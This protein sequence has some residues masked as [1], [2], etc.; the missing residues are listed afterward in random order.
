MAEPLRRQHPVGEARQPR[1]QNP[2]EERPRAGRGRGRGGRQAPAPQGQPRHGIVVHRGRRIVTIRPNAFVNMAGR[3]VSRPR[4][5]AWIYYHTLVNPNPLYPAGSQG[6]PSVRAICE[7]Y[8][9]DYATG[10]PYIN[11]I[12]TLLRETGTHPDRLPDY[13]ETED[14][15]VLTWRDENGAAHLRMATRDDS[16]SRIIAEERRRAALPRQ[17]HRRHRNIPIFHHSDAS[18]DEEENEERRESRSRSRSPIRARSLTPV[19]SGSDADSEH[20]ED[21]SDVDMEVE[22]NADIAGPSPPNTPPMHAPASP[23]AQPDAGHTPP[24]AGA[25]INDLMSL[26]EIASQEQRNAIRAFLGDGGPPTVQ[27]VA[28]QMAQL[29]V[30]EQ[31]AV[32]LQFPVANINV[33]EMAAAMEMMPRAQRMEL[34][35]AVMEP[36][37]RDEV[38]ALLE[39][40]VDT[41]RENAPFV[42][43]R[44][45][46]FLRRY[47]PVPMQ[48]VFDSVTML[49]R[50]IVVFLH[51]TPL[52]IHEVKWSVCYLHQQEKK[53]ELI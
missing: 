22:E 8:E 15:E 31:R 16:P 39:M 13:G 21:G 26:I 46:I 10:L 32:S 12:R 47:R 33:G 37:T 2:V 1:Q 18:S 50:S 7:R 4:L 17:Q 24:R 43:D 53:S 42:F 51:L 11:A 9:L 52:K 27:S 6:S 40:I 14:D 28:D 34:R 48:Y 30:Q 25:G 49:M 23:P 19:P 29:T 45:E 35:D 3:W 36:F 20:E 44:V 5:A 38:M 41:D